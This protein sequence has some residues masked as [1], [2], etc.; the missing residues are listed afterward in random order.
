MGVSLM[1]S[2]RTKPVMRFFSVICL[3][4]LLLN[5][6]SGKPGPA[7][8]VATVTQTVLINTSTPPLPSGTATPTP[9]L[10][11][12]RDWAQF[13]VTLQAMK[14]PTAT[15]RTPYPT[16]TIGPLPPTSTPWPTPSAVPGTPAVV[17]GC[18]KTV[19]GLHVI[20]NSF[21]E[22]HHNVNSYFSVL[23]HLSAKPGYTLDLVFYKDMLGFT[24]PHIYSRPVD[25]KPYISYEEFINA[26]GWP[27]Q[28]YQSFGNLPHLDLQVAFYYYLNSVRVDNTSDSFFQYV[29]LGIL[30]EQL[31]SSLRDSYN[32]TIVLCNHSDV[33]LAVSE[34]KKFVEGGGES[35]LSDQDVKDAQ[36][37]SI[38]PV[39]E[40][41]KDAAIVRIVIFTKW[42][43]FIELKYE[44]ARNF[45]HQLMGEWEQALVPYYCGCAIQ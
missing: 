8:T 11:A 28:W 14:T 16:R 27:S 30:A 10:T 2:N 37:L 12:T 24:L 36:K 6:C 5:A 42:G 17:S 22:K 29:I 13:Q 18:R 45:P 23:N 44:L 33:D 26:V 7:A 31:K 40:L 38:E 20:A 3:M 43:G 34:V 21:T 19:D 15:L 39:V 35:T 41:G 1:S 32:D 9:N 4:P 25:Q